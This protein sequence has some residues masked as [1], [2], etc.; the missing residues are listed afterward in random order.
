MQIV[1]SPNNI[2]FVSI[3]VLGFLCVAR[4]LAQPSIGTLTYQYDGH[5]SK[6]GSHPLL[7]ET[8]SE[9]L[10]IQ[11]PLY[12]SWL[13]P[14]KFFVKPD[15]CLEELRINGQVVSEPEIRFCDY[16]TL[17]RDINLKKYLQPGE[18]TLLFIIKDGGGKGGL[19]LTPSRTDVVLF[20]LNIALVLFAAIAALLLIIA[21]GKNEQKRM[22]LTIFVTGAALRFFYLL[23]TH[24]RVRSHDID[25]HIR[26]IKYVAQHFWMPP[27]S[28]GFVFHHPPLYF[29]FS[30]L[31]VRFD[32]LIHR[33]GE[34]MLFDLQV[35]SFL[36]SLATLGVGIWICRKLFPRV[37]PYAALFFSLLITLPALVFLS[38][39]ISNNTLYTFFAFVS[40]GLLVQWWQ[41]GKMRDWYLLLVVLSLAF[42]TRVS[43]LVFFPVVFLLMPFH[44]KGSWIRKI[45]HSLAGILL[46]CILAGWFPAARFL[47]ERDHANMLQLGNTTMHSG[48]LLPTRAPNLLTFN[49]AGFLTTPFNHPWNDAARRQYFPE[50]FFRS[51]FFGEFEFPK[52]FFNLAVLI[53][54]AATLLLPYFVY[55]FWKR[56]I[57]QWKKYLPI[58][59]LLFL[60]VG[61]QYWYRIF[62]P[63][64]SNQDFRHST[65]IILPIA[66]FLIAGI[67]DSAKP[68]GK[69]G[70]YLI[71]ILTSLCA[72]FIVFLYF[73]ET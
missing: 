43:A 67:Q 46:V 24:Y 11:L 40:F 29:F 1:L 17:G 13:H 15:D 52:E 65:P 50:Y 23:A 12:L 72:A 26:Y 4:L 71:T 48:L 18:N 63:Y 44:M 6:T 9:K 20:T 69:F 49:P 55:G 38:A 51:A 68:L 8:E 41:S 66:F 27:A 42:V 70:R 21:V 59:L 19:R 61:A 54:A 2:T 60:M 28:E 5:E 73:Y 31:L 53:L 25:D 33:T 45:G 16:S 32:Q 34:L 36:I 10:T 47:L 22:L 56:G 62:A 35:F 37:G 64:S 14:N 7:V 3:L 30:A 58:S 39:R 57:G